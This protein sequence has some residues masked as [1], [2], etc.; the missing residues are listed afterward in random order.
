MV[1]VDLS[2]VRSLIVKSRGHFRAGFD[3]FFSDE[4][5][6]EVDVPGLTTPVLSQVKW[7]RMPRPMFPLDPDMSWMP[8]DPFNPL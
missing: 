5:I 7:E 2:K 6:V 8:P 1:G 4:R 3:E